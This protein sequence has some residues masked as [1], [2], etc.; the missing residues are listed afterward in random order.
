VPEYSIVA[1]ARSSYRRLSPT[2]PTVFALAIRDP[3]LTRVRQCGHECGGVSAVRDDGCANARRGVVGTLRPRRKGAVNHRDDDV[4]V[5]AALPPPPDEN[6]LPV[7]VFNLHESSVRMSPSRTICSS[8]LSCSMKPPQSRSLVRRRFIG[9]FFRSK[10]RIDGFGLSGFV[11]RRRHRVWRIRRN[12]RLYRFDA[13]I[14]RRHVAFPAPW[15]RHCRPPC[16]KCSR[17][18][19]AL[20]PTRCTAWRSCSSLT[21]NSCAQ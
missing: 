1:H 10:V 4:P 18:L 15:V 6:R 2:P 17:T 7:L 20:E 8:R 11:V 19:S 12:K 3:R 21:L 13:F 9:W 16:R 14:C 5:A